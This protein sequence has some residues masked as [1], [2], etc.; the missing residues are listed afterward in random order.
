MIRFLDKLE[1]TEKIFLDKLEMTEKRFLRSLRSVEMTK[2]G[3]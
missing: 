3:L 1:M 2:M